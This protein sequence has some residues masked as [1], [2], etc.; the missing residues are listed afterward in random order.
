[1]LRICSEGHHTYSEIQK[2]PSDLL[3]SNADVI[4]LIILVSDVLGDCDRF[5]E[6]FMYCM[7][8]VNHEIDSIHDLVNL[9]RRVTS[10]STGTVHYNPLH[11]QRAHVHSLGNTAGHLQRKPVYDFSLIK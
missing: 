3:I 1:M 4:I 11:C 5:L 9:I 8:G 6:Y 10:E 2:V 7:R